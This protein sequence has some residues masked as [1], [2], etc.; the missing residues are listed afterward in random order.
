MQR[1][2]TACEKE[3]GS[4]KANEFV[5]KFGWKKAVEAINKAPPLD[6]KVWYFFLCNECGNG[7][8]SQEMITDSYM[9]DY[10]ACS[11]CTSEDLNTDHSIFDELKRLIYSWFLIKDYY[12]LTR[13][14]EHAISPYTAPEIKRA[15]EQAIADVE[16]VGD[17]K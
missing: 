3:G 7:G 13:A 4:M 11:I 6:D 12:G 17:S 5:T 1:L 16:S 10:C 2:G 14:K 9:P 8:S 15:L